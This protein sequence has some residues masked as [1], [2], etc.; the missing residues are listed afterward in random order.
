[1]NRTTVYN[2][3]R[4][5]SVTTVT[6]KTRKTKEAELILGDLDRTTNHPKQDHSVSFFSCKFQ[7]ERYRVNCSGCSST[8]R[9]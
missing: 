9:S 6:V 1:M 3:V 4:R 7:Y 5:L 8:I 2:I